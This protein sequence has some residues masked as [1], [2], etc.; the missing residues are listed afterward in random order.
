MSS[1]SCPKC[2]HYLTVGMVICPRCGWKAGSTPP[3]VK[4]SPPGAS[5]PIFLAAVP[6]PNP[7]GATLTQ[8]QLARLGRVQP[9]PASSLTPPASRGRY[10]PLRLHGALNG[11]LDPRAAETFR[12]TGVNPTALVDAL[13][14]TL[15][16]L[17]FKVSWPPPNQSEAG[18]FLRAKVRSLPRG[19]GTEVTGSISLERDVRVDR[20]ETH[21]RDRRRWLGIVA[22]M[23]IAFPSLYLLIT[24]GYPGGPLAILP[25]GGGLGIALALLSAVSFTN[26]NYWSDVVLAKYRGQTSSRVKW[27]E[28]MD[29]TTDYEVQVWVVRGLSQ[30][31][32]GKVGSGRDLV[33][34]VK[35]SGLEGVLSA[36][37]SAISAPPLG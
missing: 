19:R 18:G 4:E 28:A 7:P 13:A 1:G 16:P 33:A 14:R 2:G 36:I 31:W 34:G 30:D 10:R 3:P 27:R 5:R 25:F 9:P 8:R 26:A 22:G 6:L 17:G 21:R 37:R 23:V 24:L 32:E 35:G 12:F 29:V 11:A 20:T 15:T